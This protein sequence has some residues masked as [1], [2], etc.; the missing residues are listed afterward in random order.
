MLKR[1]AL[2][3]VATSFALIAGS[4]YRVSLFQPTSVN[5]TE[6]K[7]GEITLQLN[8]NMAV[9]KQGKTMVEAP[10]KVETAPQ[11]FNNTQVGYKEGNREIRDI[12]L[13]GTNT[14]LWFQ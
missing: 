13:G 9:L 14:H 11:K 3:A 7:R 1:F 10:V 12:A 4:N 8:D 2:L 5:G 6:L